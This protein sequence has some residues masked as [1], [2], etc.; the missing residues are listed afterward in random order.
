M[1]NKLSS[2]KVLRPTAWD[3]YFYRWEISEGVILS[4]NESSF[5][6][7]LMNIAVVGYIERSFL[8]KYPNW[9]YDQMKTPFKNRS[10]QSSY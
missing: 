2:Y 5:V 6:V 8:P 7:D 9:S 10:E 3:K 1:N 4:L